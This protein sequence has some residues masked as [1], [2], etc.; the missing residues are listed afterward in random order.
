MY[1]LI[2]PVLLVGDVLA[3]REFYED[4]GFTR[5]VD[6]EEQYPEKEFAAFEFGAAIRFGVAIATDFD[7]AEAESRLWWQFETSDLD[8]VHRR[9]TAAGLLVAQPPRREPWGRRTLKL[10]SPN[11]Y[12]VTFE[13]GG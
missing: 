12:L 10:R 9:A 11:G 6:P 2:T 8:A 5:Y 1:T 3:E 7:P 4:L 13:E